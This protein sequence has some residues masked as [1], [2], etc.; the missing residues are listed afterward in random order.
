MIKWNHKQFKDIQESE[1]QKNIK[2]IHKFEA[3]KRMLKSRPDE[4]YTLIKDKWKS[5][6]TNHLLDKFW[7]SDIFTDEI[8]NK[9]FEFSNE[10]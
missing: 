1:L 8:T 5:T 3:R 7:E 4:S 10:S 6:L 2:N 9:S